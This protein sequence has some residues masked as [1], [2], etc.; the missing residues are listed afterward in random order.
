MVSSKLVKTKLHF[1]YLLV[2]LDHYILFRIFCTLCYFMVLLDTIC[3]FCNSTALF[4]TC[5][6]IFGCF[7]ACWYILDPSLLVILDH[8]IFFFGAVRFLDIFVL[9]YFFVLRLVPRYLCCRCIGMLWNTKQCHQRE[10][11]LGVS[12]YRK[13]AFH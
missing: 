5:W 13:I 9:L 11:K 4:G 2:F 6:Y 12:S 1:F 8:S 3:S 10:G 7:I